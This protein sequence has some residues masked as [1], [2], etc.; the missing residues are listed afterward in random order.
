MGRPNRSK[1]SKTPPKEKEEEKQTSASKIS[2]E[3]SSK[4]RKREESTRVDK[5]VMVESKTNSPVTKK[6]QNTKENEELIS[7]VP[8]Q[9]YGTNNNSTGILE[10]SME[11]EE[12]ASAK[13]VRARSR[14]KFTNERES[15]PSR[16]ETSKTTDQ[17]IN[18]SLDLQLEEGE[19]EVTEQMPIE[20]S[21]VASAKKQRVE[22]SAKCS[23]SD[24]NQEFM[25]QIMEELK[26]VKQQLQSK[27]LT[28]ASKINS[29]NRPLP[30]IKSPSVDTVYAPAVRRAADLPQ[31]GVINDLQ[32]EERR[33]QWE[34]QLNDFVTNIRLGTQ[35]Q[36]KQGNV[37]QPSMSGAHRRLNFEEEERN[38]E[39]VQQLARDRIVEAEKFKAT[40]EPPK[41]RSNYLIK[42]SSLEFPDAPLLDD[43]DFIQVSCHLDQPTEEKIIGS[44]YLEFDKLLGKQNR[45]TNP[46]EP[47]RGEIINGVFIGP[48]EEKGVK[49]SNVYLWEKAFRIYMSVYT[50]AHPTKAVEMVQYM[51][52][53][54]HAA[55]KYVWENV[56]QYDITFRQ[57]MEKNPNRSWGKTFNQMWNMCLCEP[58]PRGSQNPAYAGQGKKSGDRNAKGICWRFNKGICNYP[59][60]RY[61]HK[62]TYCG[63][64][65]HGAHVCFKKTRKSEGKKLEKEK[66]KDKQ[67]QT[68]RESAKEHSET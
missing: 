19:I 18:A 66:E 44:K 14:S 28:P 62:C 24:M 11:S 47:K 41:G 6:N 26:S 37:P 27:N 23:S 7:E 32:Q 3:S 48:A 54:H 10:N 8:E 51:H 35:E 40:L 16:K 5:N 65:N 49:I 64:T 53:I 12:G 68:K 22:E 67:N 63:G 34:T 33:K 60:C 58:L 9:M 4:K 59:E 57:M 13:K 38:V 56:Y 52:T 25:K 1:K 31:V 2:A 21:R 50:W 39:D 36:M 17:R 42:P 15:F 61:P 29:C 20:K 30:I 45:A 55:S 43:D 46:M